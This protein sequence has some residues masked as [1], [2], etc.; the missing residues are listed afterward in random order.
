MTAARSGPARASAWPARPSAGAADGRGDIRGSTP[1]SATVARPRAISSERRR[2]CCSER[3]IMYVGHGLPVGRR[4]DVRQRVE[5]LLLHAVVTRREQRLGQQRLEPLDDDRAAQLGR[6]GAADRRSEYTVRPEKP[7]GGG[8]RELAPRAGR[9]AATASRGAAGGD[10]RHQ[11]GLDVAPARLLDGARGLL[12][13]AGRAGV[14]V[15]EPGPGRPGPAPR[16]R[17][18]MAVRRGHGADDEVGAARP[19]CPRIRPRATGRAAAARA[20]GLPG[21]ANAMSQATRSRMARGREVLREH[22]AHLAEADEASRGSSPGSTPTPAREP[23]R[24]SAAGRCAAAP[25]CSP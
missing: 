25:S 7:S 10:G 16:R 19:P 12:L 17:R 13:V 24:A 9:R 5:H 11:R 22:R 3:E 8:R 14:Q 20:A 21:S 1:A 6:G 4:E 15:E 18:P 2:P 23:R